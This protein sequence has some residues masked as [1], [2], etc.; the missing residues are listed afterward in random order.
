MSES[1]EGALEGV[2]DPD[3]KPDPN[4]PRIMKVTADGDLEFFP[5]RKEHIAEIVRTWDNDQPGKAENTENA[6]LLLASEIGSLGERLKQQETFQKTIFGS[7]MDRLD[8]L[9][10]RMQTLEKDV[11]EVADI[12]HEIHSRIDAIEEAI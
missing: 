6:W 10:A 12:V 3:D 11:S 7:F 9:E 5:L 2:Y 8:A 4:N 1:D